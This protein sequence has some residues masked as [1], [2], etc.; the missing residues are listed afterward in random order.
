VN[1]PRV[2]YRVRDFE[3]ARTFY[4]GVLG[5]EETF[6]DFDEPWST[7]SH[8]AMHIAVTAGEPTPQGGVAMIDVEDAK[9][10]ADRLRRGG[11][12]VGTVVEVGG[13]ILLVDVFDPDGNRIQL[14]QPL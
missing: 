10:E 9:A 11:V 6:V 12:D 5:F 2:V 7:L 13:Q 8:G 3:R 4:K 14:S 1:D